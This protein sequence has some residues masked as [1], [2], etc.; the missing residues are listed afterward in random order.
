MKLTIKN[1]P[2]I[3]KRYS[4][5]KDEH[6]RADII[7]EVMY[8]ADYDFETGFADAFQEIADMFEKETGIVLN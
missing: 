6:E 5:A 8:F 7:N 3:L 2:D 1:H 4:D